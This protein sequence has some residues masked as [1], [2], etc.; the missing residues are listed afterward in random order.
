[1]AYGTN[2]VSSALTCVWCASW[3]VG[4]FFALFGIGRSKNVFAYFSELLA[5]SAGA[6]FIEETLNKL[7]G[8]K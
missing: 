7:D 2:V 5:L 1:M 6:I 8:D 4:A 3:W